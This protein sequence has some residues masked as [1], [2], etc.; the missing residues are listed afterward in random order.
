MNQFLNNYC[1]Y[2]YEFEDNSVYIGITSKEKKRHIRHMTDKSSAVFK[3]IQK[4]NLIPKKVSLFPSTNPED[5]SKLEEIFKIKYYNMG[6]NI[7]NVAQTGSLGGTIIKWSKEKCQE[8]ALK[9][10]T[11][12]EFKSK[13][14]AYSPAWKNG[15]LDEICSHMI[16]PQ[17]TKGY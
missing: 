15:W 10:N 6:W 2:A 1:G 13:S 16:S 14:L 17:K 7:L 8:E 3:H 12:S 4:S 9:Y 11:K 5:A